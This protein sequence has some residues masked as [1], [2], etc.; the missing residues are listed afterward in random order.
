MA[1]SPSDVINPAST[2]QFHNINMSNVTKLTASNFLMW[3]RQ[4]HAL[5]AGYGL[6]GYL[7]GTTVAPDATVLQGEASIPNPEYNLWEPQDQLIV[8][9][10]L[11]A[12]STEIQPMLSKLREQIKQWRKGSRTVD[13]YVQGLVV[14]FDQLAT[15]GKPYE[16]EEQI[17]YLL[18]GLPEYYKPLVE[19]IEGRDTPPSMPAIH[20]KLINYELKLLTQGFASSVVPV[21]ANAAFYKSSNNN[22]NNNSSRPH[23]PPSRGSHHHN[24]RGSHGKGYQ[25][26]CQ[27]CGV[28]GHSAR[29]CSQLPSG[30]SYQPSGGNY[31]PS[32]GP[33]TSWQPRANM[34]IVP[35]YNPGNWIMDSGAT[36]HLTSDLANLSLHQPCTGGE[37]V[38]IA[39]GSG[40]KITHTGSTSLPT[41][42]RSLD[43]KDI[44]Y[45]LDV[46]KN[47]I[48][49]FR[50]CN[51]NQVSVHF[52]PALFQVRDLSTGVKLL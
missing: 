52:Y 4:V 11:G 7:D 23:R 10:L 29:R 42:S 34:A 38:Q 19:Q 41:S 15:L 3:N 22:N 45:V 50:L 5:L 1:A 30:G 18:G 21:T 36:H 44:L 28:F 40:L 12:I 13:E 20:E 43:L 9:S 48:S 17:E 39:D 33:S 25:G 2:S 8:A 6:V 35:P 46:R 47:L 24:S 26:R 14:R 16:H 27:L 31:Q 49:V 32:G 51:T 37:E